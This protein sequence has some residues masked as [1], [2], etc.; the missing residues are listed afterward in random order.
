MIFREGLNIRGLNT[1]ATLW[2]SAAVGL[3]AGAGFPIYGALCAALV[4]GSSLF[5]RLRSSTFRPLHRSAFD[6]SRGSA[7]LFGMSR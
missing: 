4:V 5:G 1:A 7:L 2:C 3:L 6:I